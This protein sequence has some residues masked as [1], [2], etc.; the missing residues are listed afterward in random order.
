MRDNHLGC[1]QPGDDLLEV[2]LTA[3]RGPPT[4]L[5]P[6]EVGHSLTVK[7]THIIVLNTM[8][9]DTTLFKIPYMVL[10]E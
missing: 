9:V 4:S 6:G 3:V 10:T 5:V 7:V 8:T 1:G 2:S